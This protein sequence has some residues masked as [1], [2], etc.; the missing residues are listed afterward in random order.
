[1]SDKYRPRVYTCAICGT[2]FEHARRAGR[3]PLYCPACKAALHVGSHNTKYASTPQPINKTYYNHDPTR[4]VVDMAA[5]TPINGIFR[6]INNYDPPTFE[7]CRRW[8]AK[9]GKNPSVPYPRC[10]PAGWRIF[11]R[12]IKRCDYYRD[13][14]EEP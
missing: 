12:R 6:N 10:T 4:S 14:G 9:H 11:L 5:P 3:P 13:C 1:M 2:K 7:D 8:Y